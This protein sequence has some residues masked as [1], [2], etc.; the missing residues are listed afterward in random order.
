M[1]NQKIEQLNI[2]VAI[3]L[4]YGL[5]EQTTEIWNKKWKYSKTW[6]NDFINEV[7]LF[8]SEE[9]Q[10]KYEEFLNNF[11]DNTS[12]VF[13][14][15]RNRFTDYGSKNEEIR[16]VKE[17]YVRLED[18]RILEYNKKNNSNFINKKTINS[19]I[20]PSDLSFINISIDCDE[21]EFSLSENRLFDSK[22]FDFLDKLKLISKISEIKKVSISKNNS[23]NIKIEDK[24][25]LQFY[26]EN[27]DIDYKEYSNRF[28]SSYFLKKTGIESIKTLYEANVLISSDGSAIIP[29]YNIENSIAFNP[30]NIKSYQNIKKTFSGEFIKLFNGNS[31][32]C[33][34]N[35][36]KDTDLKSNKIFIGEGVATCLSIKKMI[37]G[38]NTIICAFNADNLVKV[39][40][41]LSLKYPTLEIVVCCDKDKVRFKYLE[42]NFIPN[43]IK[44]GKGF[45]ILKDILREC[46]NIK[47]IK[48]TYPEFNDSI[49]NSTIISYLNSG[50]KRMAYSK[51][52]GRSDFN[53]LNLNI[54]KSLSNLNNPLDLNI[55]N[56]ENL[57]FK[58]SIENQLGHS[59]VLSNNLL[60]VIPLIKNENLIE[61]ATNIINNKDFRDDFYESFGDSGI[62]SLIN[63]IESKEIIE[64]IILKTKDNINDKNIE[65]D[66]Y[67][68][69]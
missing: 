21:M 3:F 33:F 42:N 39:V 8:S 13:D 6:E 46:D 47:N 45:F 5:S 1:Q 41:E 9:I 31:S 60:N 63:K 44:L 19:L 34:L 35:F 29:M 26:N 62:K 25:Y 54:E 27:K 32:N 57:K 2:S 51:D 38:Q 61:M 48:F 56:I 37:K 68:I 24:S 4:L 28:K 69:K 66:F 59:K 10:E 53:D 22:M 55:E 49:D 30:E 11:S 36:N 16:R 20:Y 67:G 64:Q 7:E 15:K 43:E 18:E 23:S 50:H 14:L 40:K 12:L 17:Q 65:G 58:I 52:I